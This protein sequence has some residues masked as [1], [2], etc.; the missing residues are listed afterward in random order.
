MIGLMNVDQMFTA[1]D[2]I[3]TTGPD[4][5]VGFLNVAFN[6]EH[7]GIFVSSVVDRNKSVHEFF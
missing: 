7:S 1:E 4:A 5:L 6:S 2:T 3:T